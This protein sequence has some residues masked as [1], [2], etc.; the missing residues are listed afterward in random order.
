MSNWKE[1][2][3]S[4][5]PV[6]GTA[7]GGP[8]A[9]AAVN[10]LAQ[11]MLGDNDGSQASLEKR[12]EQHIT[13]AGP[14]QLLKLRELDQEFELQMEQLGVDVFKL[15]VMDR[16]S[17]RKH[18]KDS[19]MPAVL[20]LLLTVLVAVG[21]GAL[22]QVT[23]PEANKNIVYMVFGQVMTAWAASVAYWVGSSKGSADKT[24]LLKGA[25]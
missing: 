7:L 23:I 14:D 9:G 19:R 2:V 3:K 22:M 1:I 17:A 20:C 15:E 12:L 6:I 25:V 13:S 16:D 10:T 21:T 8:M 24:K 11:H 18:N 4:I 5:A